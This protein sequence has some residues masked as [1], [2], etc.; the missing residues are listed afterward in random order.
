MCVNEADLELDC[1]CSGLGTSSD[2]RDSGSVVLRPEC[3]MLSVGRV[4]GGL[5]PDGLLSEIFLSE[6]SVADRLAARLVSSRLAADGDNVA[7]VV[8]AGEVER[9]L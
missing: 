6:I 5:C 9:R 8:S 2:R 1:W 3:D 7:D 4:G